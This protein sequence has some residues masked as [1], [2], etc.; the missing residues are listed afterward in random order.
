M[1]QLLIGRAL[2]YAKTSAPKLPDTRSRVEAGMWKWK[3]W[4]WLIFCGSG[5]T[6]IKEVGSGSELGSK[7]VEKELEAEAFFSKSGSSEFSNW[8]QPLG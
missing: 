5:S 2:T 7:S 3:R 6:L 4:K 1:S 8:L